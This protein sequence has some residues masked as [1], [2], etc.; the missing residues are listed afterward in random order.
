MKTTI[1]AVLTRY[2]K[3]TKEWDEAKRVEL[4]K[5]IL[6]NNRISQRKYF[7]TMRQFRKTGEE[8]RAPRGMRW[9]LETEEG[10]RMAKDC[11]PH[12]ASFV[13]FE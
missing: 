1:Y 2:N 13:P 4:C 8:M 3:L 6:Y 9:H 12:I 5:A 7:D 11:N 10:L